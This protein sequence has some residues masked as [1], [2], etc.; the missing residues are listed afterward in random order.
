VNQVSPVSF[1][2]IFLD[3]SEINGNV[4]S[5]IVNTALF[6]SSPSSMV[7]ERS[8]SQKF[9]MGCLPLKTR[10]QSMRCPVREEIE[11]VLELNAKTAISGATELNYT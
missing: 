1:G 4:Y 5:G 2:W 7:N 11:V 3:P 9:N 6:N 10:C 8:Y